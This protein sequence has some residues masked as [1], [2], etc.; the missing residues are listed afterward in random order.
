MKEHGSSTADR[1]SSVGARGIDRRTVLRV[2]AHVAWTAPLV[3]LATAVPALA[4]SGTAPKLAVSGSGKWAGNS[5]K[6]TLIISVTNSGGQP[7]ANVQVTITLPISM[8]SSA[9]SGWSTSSNGASKT[10]TY[11]DPA[12]LAAGTTS[13][14]NVTLTPANSS[15][16]KRALDIAAAVTAASPAT[17][18][19]TLIQVPAG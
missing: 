3:Q 14:L 12:Q 15:D 13:S 2:G 4:A 19:S 7:A 16:D 17:G 5:G 8:T 11:T 6:A 1:G 9:K 18:G 10:F